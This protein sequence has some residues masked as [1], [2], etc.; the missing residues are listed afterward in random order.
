MKGKSVEGVL[1]GIASI[2]MLLF[3]QPVMALTI[4]FDTA[5]GATEAGGNAVAATAVFTT[6]VGT[7]DITLTNLLVNPLTIAQNL[8]DL[9][10]HVTTGEST[11][12]LSSSSG[13]ERTIAANGT[14]TDG[15]VVAAGWVLTTVGTDLHLDVL[16]GPGHAGP[17]HTIVGLPDGSNVY[18]NANGSIAGNGPHNPFL[19]GD[20]TFS[21]NVAGVTA[22]SSIDNVLF[23]FGTESGN[24]VPG[25]GPP[26]PLVPEPSTLL[27]LGAG[28][29]GLGLLARRRRNA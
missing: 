23:S 28:L 9:T 11:G 8:S 2:G 18:S 13:L 12:T 26:P 27:L 3:A 29:S 22:A 10:F 17:A 14:F 16:S 19:F 5:A 24:N 1:A 20:V 21:L 6:G 4:Q 25:E 7:I 15:A